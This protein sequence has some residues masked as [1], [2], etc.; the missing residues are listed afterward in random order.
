MKNISLIL[1]LI[2]IFNSCQ[3]RHKLQNMS[4]AIN[5]VNAVTSQRMMNRRSSLFSDARKA[6][7][8]KIPFLKQQPIL[9]TIYLMESFNYETALVTGTVWNKNMTV[10]YEFR[11]KSKEENLSLVSK[12]AFT[13]FQMKLVNKWDTIAIRREESSIYNLPSKYE[14]NAYRCIILNKVPNVDRFHF[15]DFFNPSRDGLKNN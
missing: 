8:E 1:V 2:T 6:A 13:P 10:S 4:D 3:S 7:F 5:K 15:K 12:S 14:I 11:K 9:D